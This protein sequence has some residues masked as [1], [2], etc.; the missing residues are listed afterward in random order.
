MKKIIS[1]LFLSICASY[2]AT[3]FS[4]DTMKAREIVEKATLT[5][6]NF[7][8]DPNMHY[9]RERVADAEGLLIIPALLKG[10][11]IV[12]GSGGTGVLVPKDK[13]GQWGNPTFYTMGSGSVGFQFGGEV[14]EIILMVMTENGM[15]SL[16]TS[17][18]KLGA[19]ASVAAGPVGIG[20][21]GQT[22]DI[23]AY[24]RTKGAFAGASVEGAVIKVRDKH[25]AAYYG[26]EVRPVDIIVSKNVSS[27]H[28]DALRN[29]VAGLISASPSSN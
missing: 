20:A 5:V 12:G 23:L 10:A 14:S 25:N 27:P 24:S 11:F 8:V 6:K 21:K 19:D 16:L 2:S 28:A 4:N 26:K 17:S 1:A 18:M 7:T 13:S 29:A 3:T 22:A 15:N 9:L